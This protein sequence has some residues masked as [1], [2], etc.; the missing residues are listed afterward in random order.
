MGDVAA[1]YSGFSPALGYEASPRRDFKTP[2]TDFIAPW[3]MT[4]IVIAPFCTAARQ[5]KRVF[6][7][8]LRLPAAPPYFAPM[9]LDAAANG[10]VAV[11]MGNHDPYMCPHNAYRCRGDD[12]WVVISV[13]S[14]CEWQAFCRVVADDRISGDE[15]FATLLARKAHENELDELIPN[16]L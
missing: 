3:Y 10:R 9:L 11:P 6:W 5:A 8:N 2:I 13:E 16:G 7:T 12:R 14:D 4:S 15:K 1:T